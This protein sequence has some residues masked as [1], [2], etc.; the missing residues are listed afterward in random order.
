MSEPTET[1]I[2][3]PGAVSNFPGSGPSRRIPKP[4][5]EPT[6]VLAPH[7]QVVDYHVHAPCTEDARDIGGRMTR[8]LHQVG[9]VLADTIVG[10]AILARPGGVP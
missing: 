5:P 4:Y 8:F 10:H 2:R 9:Y 3:P 7:G 6:L 1:V